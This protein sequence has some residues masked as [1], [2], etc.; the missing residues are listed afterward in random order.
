LTQLT[1]ANTDSFAPRWSPGQ[2]Y[3]AFWRDHS[4]Y[5][6]EAIGEANGGRSFVVAPAGFAGSAWSPDGSKLVFMGATGGLYIVSVNAA[7]GTVGTPALFRAG[8]YYDPS[9][10]PDGS[11]IAFWGSD[12]GNS[13]ILITVR[14]MITGNEFSFG[15]GSDN[16]C[17]Q[18]SPDGR[19]IAFLAPAQVSGTVY[20]QIFLANADGSNI[21][22]VTHL[23]GDAFFPT[24]SPDGTTLAF[25]GGFSGANGIYTVVLGSGTVHL[26]YSSNINRPDWGFPISIPTAP[27]LD[28]ISSGNQMIL[29]WPTNAVFS[30]QAAPFATG[31]YTNV[32]G[33]SSPYTNLMTQPQR[34]F[35]LQ[36]N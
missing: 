12:D 14:N 10:S 8:D 5:V 22:Q 32:P 13:P 25:R 9:W 6:M 35:R 18:W 24:W 34:F 19:R 16:H 11:S 28:F 7:T 31:T 33:A 15:V 20:E 2:R 23:E 27:F 3:I 26:V 36:A 17:P 4:L 30:L 1:S 29:S 21:T